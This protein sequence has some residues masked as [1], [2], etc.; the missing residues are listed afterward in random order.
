MYYEIT[1]N[2]N[3]KHSF[4]DNLQPQVQ[5]ERHISPDTR[6]DDT[7]MKT[8]TGD[9]YFIFYLNVSLHVSRKL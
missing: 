9:P 5:W 4:D 1:F 8:I 3:L 2:A 6:V 7:G